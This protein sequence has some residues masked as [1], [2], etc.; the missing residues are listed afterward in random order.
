MLVGAFLLAT[1]H[2]VWGL[3]ALA[4]VFPAALWLNTR[5]ITGLEHWVS[6]EKLTPNGKFFSRFVGLPILTFV[7]LAFI[8]PGGPL[9]ARWT[10]TNPGDPIAQCTAF[11]PKTVGVVMLVELGALIGWSILVRVRNDGVLALLESVPFG[12]LIGTWFTAGGLGIALCRP[13][14]AFGLLYPLTHACL[15]AVAAYCIVWL[16]VRLPRT[17]DFNP[18][19]Y[20][21]AHRQL[22]IFGVAA[23][24][25]GKVVRP[26]HY[27]YVFAFFA[28]AALLFNY[29][30]GLVVAR[31]YVGDWEAV[32]GMTACGYLFFILGISGVS[33]AWHVARRLRGEKMT[34]KEFSKTDVRFRP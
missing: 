10:H 23:R 17:I 29:L 19:V 6:H 28:G 27:L 24:P 34:I 12:V 2:I 14:P 20:D 25:D 11:D 15:L 13:L 16:H 26:V 5:F 4:L 32:I 30:L 3:I 22:A 1:M 33:T 9:L 21:F 18:Q 7:A 31:R 8:Y